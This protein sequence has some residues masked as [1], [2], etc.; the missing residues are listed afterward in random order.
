MA[1][2]LQGRLGIRHGL[3]RPPGRAA[4]P[5]S[6]A[7]IGRD[8]HAPRRQSSLW[9]GDAARHRGAAPQGTRAAPAF[10][11]PRVKAVQIVDLSGPEGALQL[12]DVPEPEPK[13]MLSPDGAV[14]VEVHAAGVSFPEVLQT[15]GEY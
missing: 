11:I 8:P 13:H 10:T 3:G 4:R 7:R 6:Q 1:R 12:S 9:Q 15:R 2:L 5:R 14:V